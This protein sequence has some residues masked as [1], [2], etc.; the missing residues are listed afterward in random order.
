V[1][2]MVDAAQEPVDDWPGGRG[3]EPTGPPMPRLATIGA[4][5]RLTLTGSVPDWATATRISQVAGANLPAGVDGVNNQL[6]WHPDAPSDIRSG[7]V[8][9]DQAATFALGQATIE[10]ASYPT[11][12]LAAELLQSRPSLFVVVIGH[13]D[14]VGDEELNAELALDRANAVVGYLVERGVV[15]GQIVVAS[16]GEDDPTASNETQAG[17]DANRR[18]E[19]QFKNF[20]IPPQDFGQPS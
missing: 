4:D 3:P 7:D 20:F 1:E 9:I 13:T 14:N 11:L 19:L 17:R 10:P 15:P 8:L 5:G 2:T 12:D 16:A 6:S 18:I